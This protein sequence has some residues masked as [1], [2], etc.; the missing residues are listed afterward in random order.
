MPII[1]N[2]IKRSILKPMVKIASLF[3][4]DKEQR[5]IFR[6]NILH[7]DTI[8]FIGNSYAIKP[9]NSFP[10]TK[11]GK[12]VSIASNVTLGL[13]QHPINLVSTSPVVY[14]NNPQ[15]LDAQI[16][17]KS[18]EVGHDVW[19][20]S[21][22]MVMAGVHIHTGAVVAAGSVVTKDV[23]P[24]A[25]VGGVPAKIIKYRFDEPTR[26]KLLASEWWEYSPQVIK[27]LPYD[28]IDKFLSELEKI[29]SSAA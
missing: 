15:Y 16:Y 21:G 20:G 11:I 7:N 17:G 18:V 9:F 10:D 8:N 2:K 27:K 1:V 23:P 25:I 3:I 4:R 14:N 5:K 26:N 19:I 6:K 24:Y 28:D 29:K 13:W 22:A 12:Y